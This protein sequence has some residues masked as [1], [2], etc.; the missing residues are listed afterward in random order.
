MRALT[1]SQNCAAASWPRFREPALPGDVR[2]PLDQALSQLGDPKMAAGVFVAGRG[3]KG[4][5]LAVAE[6]DSGRQIAIVSPTNQSWPFWPATRPG[7]SVL[8]L[9]RSS[10]ITSF[11]FRSATGRP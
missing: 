8:L 3:L 5:D 2:N 7:R 10:T 9:G 6:F 11:P 4:S 1:G